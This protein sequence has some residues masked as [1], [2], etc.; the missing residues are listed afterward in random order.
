[1]IAVKKMGEKKISVPQKMAAVKRRPQK[2]IDSSSQDKIS[3]PKKQRLSNHGSDEGDCFVD[4]LPCS[5]NILFLPERIEDLEAIAKDIFKQFGEGKYANNNELLTIL[6]D[7]KEQKAIDSEDC[8]KLIN[9]IASNY[10]KI[11]RR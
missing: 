5:P 6:D 2:M 3:S 7:F 10:R 11:R 9:Y 1:M 4:D 8:R